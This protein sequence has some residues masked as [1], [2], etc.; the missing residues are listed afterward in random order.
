MHDIGQR[1]QLLHALV[2]EELQHFAL[3][4][5]AWTLSQCPAMPFGTRESRTRDERQCAIR[6]PP[7]HEVVAPRQR[8]LLAALRPRAA[9]R[10]GLSA[11]LLERLAVGVLHRAG[12]VV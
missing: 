8:V 9:M 4:Y 3:R 10:C 6:T 5:Q 2:V 11:S 7:L 12:W 1:V